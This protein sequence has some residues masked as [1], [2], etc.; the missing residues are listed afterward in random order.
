[1]KEKIGEE[2][3]YLSGTFDRPLLVRALLNFQNV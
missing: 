2:S 3:N 1:M